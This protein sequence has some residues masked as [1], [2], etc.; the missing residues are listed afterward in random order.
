MEELK[1]AEIKVSYSTLHQN[2]ARIAGSESAYKLLFSCWDKTIIEYQEEFKVLLLNRAHKV[3]GIYPVSK[4]GVSGTLVDPKLIFGVALKCNASSIILAHNYP[5]G[6]LS[7]SESDKN[8]TK[9][10]I[11]AGNLL[12][13]KVLDHLILTNE[14]YYSFADEGI[15][16]V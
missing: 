10:L 1:I 15:M 13:I 7:P 2:K 4:G 9:K 6:H 14:G 12:D 11:S 16:Y 8:L 3:L 5:S